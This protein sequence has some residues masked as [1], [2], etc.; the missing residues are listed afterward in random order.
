MHIVI[1][2]LQ[3]FISFKSAGS[4]K[5]SSA[6]DGIPTRWRTGINETSLILH[7]LCLTSKP[8]S[9]LMSSLFASHLHPFTCS[10]TLTCPQISLFITS[11]RHSLACPPMFLLFFAAVIAFPSICTRCEWSALI[12]LITSP[13][14]SLP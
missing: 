11:L 4:T 5:I 14:H 7:C 13:L 10:Q 2:R 3:H 6:A 1:D 9:S 12:S 8:W